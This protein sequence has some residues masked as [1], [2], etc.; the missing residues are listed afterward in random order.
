[1]GFQ[2]RILAGAAALALGAALQGCVSDREP[3]DA[4]TEQ[5][6]RTRIAALAT[7]RGT[8]LAAN[9]EI[10]GVYMR[11]TSVPYLIDALDSDSRPEVR[12]G[13]AQALGRSQ[14]GRAVEPLAERA[15][16]DGNPGV[17][18]TAAYNLCLFRDP[19]GLPVLFEALREGDAI[20]RRLANDGLRSLTGLDFGYDPMADPVERAAAA[21]RWEAWYRSV[22]Q[23]E[24]GRSLATPG[25]PPR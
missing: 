17:R 15:R 24:A 25:S 14:D 12:A 5:Q 7:L 10:L 1:M 11:A 23:G 20:N 6:I 13:C 21:G 4:A 22:G 3:V 18:Y 2:R 9:I 8:D 19:R 16:E